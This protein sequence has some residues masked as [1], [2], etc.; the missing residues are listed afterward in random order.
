M[1]QGQPPEESGLHSRVK[2]TQ[3]I[4]GAAVGMLGICIPLSPLTHSGPLIPLAVLCAAGAGTMA[5]WG[6]L[7]AKQA[8]TREK[9]LPSQSQVQSLEERLA[10]LE[11]ITNLELQL[12][13]KKYP[14][15]APHSVSS[16]PD[17]M[18]AP[19][20]TSI[21]KDSSTPASD[22]PRAGSWRIAS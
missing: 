7:S 17:S 4:W 15:A 14:G 11:A 3:Q 13:D 22:A 19:D 6:H 8:R 18:S 1:D 10:N 12:L 20:M 5:V 2:T 9:P 21:P 16:A